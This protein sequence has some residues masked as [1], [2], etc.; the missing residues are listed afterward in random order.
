MQI[1]TT[2]APPK[3]LKTVAFEVFLKALLFHLNCWKGNE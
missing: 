2:L 1:F 3:A